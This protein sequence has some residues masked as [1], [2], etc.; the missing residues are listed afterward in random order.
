MSFPIKFT[1]YS[2]LE[3]NGQKYEKMQGFISNGQKTIHYS[4]PQNTL[5]NSGLLTNSVCPLNIPTRGFP[6]PYQ[7]LGILKGA[8]NYPLFG[9][10]QYPGSAKW[11]YYTEDNSRHMNQIPIPQGEYKFEL[12]DNDIVRIPA[13][14]ACRVEMYPRELSYC[15]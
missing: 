15:L 1:Q 5:P 4:S 6:G 11:Q 2:V 12:Y 8:S 10:Q 14:G 3:V 9:R 7:K 13:L